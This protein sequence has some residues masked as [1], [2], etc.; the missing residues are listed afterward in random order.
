VTAS[1]ADAPAAEQAAITIE[2]GVMPLFGSGGLI[3][4]T[5]G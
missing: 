1:N 2:G 5:S 4:T 3:H